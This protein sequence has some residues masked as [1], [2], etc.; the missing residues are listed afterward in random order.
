MATTGRDPSSGDGA[1]RVGRQVQL[2]TDDRCVGGI[3]EPVVYQRRDPREGVGRLSR[4]GHK[5][6]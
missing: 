5:S 2:V 6:V 4:T 3:H 1:I